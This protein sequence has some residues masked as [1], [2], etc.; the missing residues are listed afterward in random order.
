MPIIGSTKKVAQKGSKK[1]AQKGPKTEN[2]GG[3]YGSYLNALRFWAIDEILKNWF[4]V[5]NGKKYYESF[6]PNNVIDGKR[7]KFGEWQKDSCLECSERH[8]HL[9][10]YY[11]DHIKDENKLKDAEKRAVQSN[12]ILGYDYLYY[13]AAFL[14]ANDLVHALTI[15]DIVMG[16]VQKAIDHYKDYKK[17]NDK[18]AKVDDNDFKHLKDSRSALAIMREWIEFG[19]EKRG[20]KYSLIF[21]QNVRSVDKESQ[22]KLN[23][24]RIDIK[25]SQLIY[26]IDG[27]IALV[28]EIGKDN[29]IKYAIEQSYFFEPKIVKDRM[30]E[31]VNA[32]KDKPTDLPARSSNK[33]VDSDDI[34]DGILDDLVDVTAGDDTAS[35]DTASDDVVKTYDENSSDIDLYYQYVDYLR[36]AMNYAET[37][38]T[39]ASDAIDN[40]KKKEDREKAAK[41]ARTAF[42]IAKKAADKANNSEIA[43][44]IKTADGEVTDAEEKVFGDNAPKNQLSEKKVEEKVKKSKYR[45]F[46]SSDLKEG[47]PVVIDSD[48]NKAVRDLIENIS[49]YSVS[50]GIKSIF[51]N[52]K[53]SHIWGRAYDPR[54]FT[55]LWNIVLVPAWANDLL[56]KNA[57]EGT[58][59]SKLKSTIMG[60][61]KALYFDRSTSKRRFNNKCIIKKD[62]EELQ[63]K[64]HPKIANT[65]DIVYSKINVNIIKGKKEPPKKDSNTEKD[66][67]VGNIVRKLV[68]IKASTNSTSKS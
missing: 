1:G 8:Y 46:Y 42:L 6:D 13:I 30:G 62:W 2:S 55:N 49:G 60:I 5:N 52:Y 37:A 34:V 65:K 32:F 7:K 24:L 23:E 68:M 64:D 17:D 61:C 66:V 33:V 58:L 26:K 54:Y 53:I 63:M 50:N 29:F 44:M 14:S 12:L 19:T 43:D 16:I 27:A 18:N 22:G 21:T 38:R 39:K 48:G 40:N 36:T 3:S 11:I 56:D 51:Q 67:V 59:E 4:V 9:C 31:I 15:I 35:D 47:Y 45:L 20:G 41:A 10:K 57:V 28:R 25:K